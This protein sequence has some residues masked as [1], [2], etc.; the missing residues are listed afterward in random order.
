MSDQA[1]MTT[2]VKEYTKVLEAKVVV[3]VRS[4]FLKTHRQVKYTT[5]YVG[6]S[7]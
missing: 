2:D 1:I 6:T 3:N 4:S 5:C 7:F